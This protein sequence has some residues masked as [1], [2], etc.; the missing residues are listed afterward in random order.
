MNAVAGADELEQLMASGA[1]APALVAAFGDADGDPND[2]IRN[3]M[4]LLQQRSSVR[5]PG[6][7]GAVAGGPLSEAAGADGGAADAG[8]GTADSLVASR[9]PVHVSSASSDAPVAD[10]T[11]S[12]KPNIART[13][14]SPRDTSIQHARLHRKPSMRSVSYARVLFDHK[15]DRS[16][17]LSLKRGAVVAVYQ[18]IT[19]D[20]W[21]GAFRDRVGLLPANFLQPLTPLGVVNALP[22]K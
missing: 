18:R 19:A 7:E 12:S 21:K 11:P 16:D 8:V 17:V 5:A 10:L 9:V 3:A 13:I 2:N 22:T 1:V 14:V 15:S 6:A 4:T 20:W